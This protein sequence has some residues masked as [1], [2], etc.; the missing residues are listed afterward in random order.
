VLEINGK[1]V[2]EGRVSPSEMERRLEGEI[3]PRHP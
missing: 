2:A 3:K 1:I